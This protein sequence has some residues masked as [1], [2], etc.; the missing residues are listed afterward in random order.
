MT[1]GELINVY[2]KNISGTISIYV[3]KCCALKPMS[4]GLMHYKWL[5]FEVD[6]FHIN[7][8]ILIIYCHKK[9]E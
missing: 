7:N 5:E 6:S 8:D 2:Q 9:E 4:I 1:I 3:N